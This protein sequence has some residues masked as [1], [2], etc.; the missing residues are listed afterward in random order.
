MMKR[1]WKKSG[2][3]ARKLYHPRLK[4]HWEFTYRRRYPRLPGAVLAADFALLM[5]L[6][7]LFVFLIFSSAFLPLRPEE[8]L[9]WISTEAP[10]SATSGEEITLV[11]HYGNG[12]DTAVSNAVL[13]INAPAGFEV[14]EGALRRDLGMIAAGTSGS[15]AITGKLF[16]PSSSNAAFTAQFI[17]WEPGKAAPTR[18]TSRTLVPITSSLLT[19]AIETPERF[20]RG[21]TG[22][23]A[24]NATNRSAAPLSNIEIRLE[25]PPDFHLSGSQPAAV[26]QNT[27]RLAELAPGATQTIT[28]YGW[29]RASNVDVAAPIFSASAFDGAHLLEEARKN[30]DPLASGFEL[31]HEI[32]SPA[33]AEALPAGATVQLEIRYRNSGD[34]EIRN[35]HFG[36]ELDPRFVVA[37]SELPVL[38]KVQ[39]GESGVISAEVRLASLLTPELLGAEGKAVLRLAARATFVRAGDESR[40]VTTESA[41]TELPFSSALGL[42]AAALYYS[43][44]G[45]Q[46]GRG[47][48]PP[49]A[50]ETTRFRVFLQV[51]NGVNALKD[52]EVEAVLAPGVEWTGRTSVNAG[53]A[54]DYLPTSNAIRWLIG[55]VPAFTV[56]EDAGV[57]ASFELALT[58]DEGAEGTAA[59]ITEVRV[60]GVDTATG[61]VVRA[62]A[63]DV[64]VEVGE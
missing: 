63:S 7:G 47:P 30:A 28:A 4:H 45:D 20:V 64:V 6:S 59:L 41:A 15:H 58:P 46:L 18:V 3:L 36:L 44:G 62:S 1:F 56:A 2:A 27:W 39:P 33:D 9:D 43:A 24:I 42:K 34:I 49:V 60:R 38:D 51:T 50:G 21:R 37:Q 12:H 16:G 31:A 48:L 14:S 22:F 5:V 29:L 10:P 32:S 54:L 40:P 61:A 25:A 8:T 55:E 35:V 17:Y 26:G 57:G 19:L 52:V 13:E 53:E 11:F 23:I